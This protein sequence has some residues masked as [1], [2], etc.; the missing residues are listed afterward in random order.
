MIDGIKVLAARLDGADPKALRVTLDQLKDKLGS[1][2]VVLAT[3]SDG[4]VSL[5]AGVTKDL[6]DR[7][8]AGDLIREVAEKV[9][10]K[11]GGRP[12]M[13]QAGG[14]DPAGLPAALALVDDWVRQRV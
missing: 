6:T 2:V 13:A 9:G 11:G 10:G 5:I 7:L 3:E 12:D 8:K 14:S 1:A 4:K